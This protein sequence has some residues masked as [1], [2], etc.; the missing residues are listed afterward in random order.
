MSLRS[1]SALRLPLLALILFAGLTAE[2]KEYHGNTRSH[3][4][5][6]SSCQYYSCRNCTAQFET[7]QEAI[8]NGYRPCGLCEPTSAPRKSS[9]TAPYVGN[10]NTHK[11]HRTSCRYASC[12]NC[13]AK[14]K[15]R[16]EAIA[17]GYVPGGCCNP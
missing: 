3:V 1:L 8:D 11:F 12:A 10:T 17:A 15:S 9:K 6:R 13:T 7:A 2:G 16:E 14:F 5:H 4:F